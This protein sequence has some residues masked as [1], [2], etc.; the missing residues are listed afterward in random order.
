MAKRKTKATTASKKYVMPVVLSAAG[1][2]LA[3][4]TLYFLRD[5][6]IAKKA[7]SGFDG[8]IL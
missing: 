7:T 6:E 4:L 8:G 3:G 5:Q 2:V 1:T